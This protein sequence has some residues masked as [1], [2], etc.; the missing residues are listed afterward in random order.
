MDEPDFLSVYDRYAS[1]VY[2]FSLYLS[3][4]AA[5][6]Q[7]ITAETFARA[8]AVRD[9][10]RLGSIKGYLLMIARNLY[11]D[12][13]RRPAA[14]SLSAAAEVSDR[15]AGP[16]A[17]ADARHELQL[18]L[19]ALHELPE[20][21]R[22]VLLMA[23]VEELPHQVIGLALGLSPAAVKV[24]IHRARVKLNAARGIGGHPL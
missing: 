7:D 21:D 13:R 16:E 11:R 2:R 18:V 4:D 5:L 20:L 24:R 12:D 23:T 17:S 14:A 6:A 8:W 1:D 19:R 10:I 15:A 3:G 9:Q 22:A